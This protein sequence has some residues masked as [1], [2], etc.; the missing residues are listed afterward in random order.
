M[1]YS[2]AQKM[3]QVSI[4]G[5][6]AAGSSYLP[7]PFFF[8]LPPLCALANPYLIS[9]FKSF[10]YLSIALD[11]LSSGP[12]TCGHGIFIRFSLSGVV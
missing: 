1:G 5:A 10:M 9:D 12:V 3:L 4:F 7:L 11:F 8:F 2:R 6:S